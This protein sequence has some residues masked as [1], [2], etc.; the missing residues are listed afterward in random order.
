M[1][2]VSKTNRKVNSTPVAK[3]DYLLLSIVLFLS[4]FKSAV[5]SAEYGDLFI[6]GLPAYV[7]LPQT[8]ANYLIIVFM[9]FSLLKQKGGIRNIENKGAIIAFGIFQF[10]I[11][12]VTQEQGWVIKS[13]SVVIVVLYFLLVVSN[14]SFYKRGFRYDNVVNGMYYGGSLFCLY[15][16]AVYFLIPDLVTWKGRVFGVTMHPNFLGVAA[17]LSFIL[18]FYK[19]FEARTK[20]VYVNLYA[21]LA[22]FVSLYIVYLSD[23]RTALGLCAFGVMYWVSLRIKDYTLKS[24]FILGGTIV[25]LLTYS[26]Y[27]GGAVGSDDLGERGFNREATWEELWNNVLDPTF[28]GLGKVGATANSYLFAI[29]AT[30][31]FGGIFFYYTII[32][33]VKNIRAVSI[34]PQ[35]F[36]NVLSVALLIAAF[37]EGFLL[38]A[39]SI[40]VLF[41]W[42]LI[43][44]KTMRNAYN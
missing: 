8:Y 12:V 27:M 43:G 3:R 26:L 40:P 34:R 25:A 14:L 20:S 32:N 23:S 13:L 38:D 4:S 11:P 9:I 18:C 1:R 7:S 2:S 6:T 30:G 35:V 21:Y 31:I 29:V 36:Y 33:I 41:F 22:T 28:F 37:L 5:I 17:A 39:L 44:Y 24:V 15:N 16:L 42:I 10:M 19:L